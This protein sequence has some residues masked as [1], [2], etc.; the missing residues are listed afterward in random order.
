LRKGRVDI[1]ALASEIELGHPF[2][3]PTVA[4]L[5]SKAR[6]SGNYCGRAPRCCPIP[7]INLTSLDRKTLARG[8]SRRTALIIRRSIAPLAVAFV[9]LC[10]GQAGAQD[11]SPAPLPNQSAAP[12]AGASPFPP[13]GTAPLFGRGFGAPPP[14]SVMDRFA[15]PPAPPASAS[16]VCMQEFVPLREDAEKRG[17]L[18]KAASERKAP[19]DEACK[20]IASFSQAEVKMMKYVE[21]N[22]QRCGIPSQIAEQLKAGHKNTEALRDKVCRVAQMQ[23]QWP[24]GPPRINDIGDPAM[25]RYYLFRIH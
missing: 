5:S 17:K 24:D 19:P 4:V 20:L 16:H 21:A 6:T 10:A 22:A 1:Q 12:P 14:A 9:T 25:E 7:R 8:F 11:A 23:R 3:F 18:I 13:V 15:T 2:M